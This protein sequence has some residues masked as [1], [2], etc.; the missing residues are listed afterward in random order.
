M[1]SPTPT[2]AT[3][4]APPVSTTASQQEVTSDYDTFL[5]MMT[6]QLMNQD[7]LDP[8]DSAEF[9]MQLATFSG[10]EQQ[11]RSNELLTSIQSQ[12]VTSGMAEMAAW[13]GK[14]ARAPVAG[15]FDGS[16]ITIA[17]NPAAIADQAKLVVRDDNGNIVQEML[18]PVS[19]EPIEWAGVTTDG[20]PLPAG[21]YTFEIVSYAGG[22][23]I[24][25]ET[26]DIYTTIEE[27]RSQDGINVLVTSGGVAVPATSVTALREPG[28]P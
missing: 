4:A 28:Q 14:E 25:R 13:V 18:I 7:P 24:L 5:R 9:S 8:L 26:A 1:I 23:E 16:P 22:E 12:L 10:V 3:T 21:M 11:V 20:S 17:P 15:N 19:A 6:T 27:V 2:A